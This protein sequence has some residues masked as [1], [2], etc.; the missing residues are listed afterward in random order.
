[1]T[2]PVI[3]GMEGSFKYKTKESKDLKRKKINMCDR[4]K[5]LH[6]KILKTN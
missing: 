5:Y 4:S 2:N 1:M 6:K 3:C